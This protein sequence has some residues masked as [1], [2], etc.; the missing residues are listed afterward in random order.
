MARLR[1]VAH[2]RSAGHSWCR[3]LV[4]ILFASGACVLPAATAVDGATGGAGGSGA[5]GGSGAGGSGATGGSGAG[6]SGATGGSGAGGGV[7]GFGAGG[8]AGHT[9]EDQWSGQYGLANYEEALSVALDG[10]GNVFVT[11]VFNT[12][13]NLG[14]GQLDSIGKGD[15]FLG[16][17]SPAG[18]PLA[19]R[20]IGSLED[21]WGFTVTVGPLGGVYLGGSHRDDLLLGNATVP[22]A[23]ADEDAFIVKLNG[24]LVADWALSVAG[25]GSQATMGLATDAAENVYAY[26]VSDGDIASPVDL[27]AGASDIAILKLAPDGTVLWATAFGDGQVQSMWAGTVVAFDPVAANVVVGGMFRSQTQ[28]SLD[29]NFLGGTCPPLANVSGQPL[30]FVARLDADGHCVTSRRIG[31]PGVAEVPRLELA[32]GPTGDVYVAGQFHGTLDFSDG[33]DPCAQLV[34]GPASA[35]AFVARLG[36][37]AGWVPG[38]SWARRIGEPGVGDNG[39][40]SAGLHVDDAD[41]VT[42]AFLTSGTVSAGGETFYGTGAEEDIVM[43]KYGPSGEH[44]WSHFYA[45]AGDLHDTPRAL[46]CRQDG[47]CALVGRRG[48]DGAGTGSLDFGNTVLPPPSWFDMYVAQFAP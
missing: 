31:T 41:R 28:T 7:C 1:G 40:T 22:H 17:W 39:Q 47:V 6:G 10:T 14:G 26:V 19:S 4:P 11:G 13:T 38:V 36:P 44:L 27:P 20:P 23:S 21:E 8:E 43:A 30:G 48:T 32:L 34:A 5:T 9:G 12:T 15:A 29:W 46:A 3:V 25:T 35:D 33:A 37:D 45:T 24:S 2:G 18:A 16:K 42:V